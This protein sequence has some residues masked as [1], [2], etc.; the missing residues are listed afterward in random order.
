M[1]PW[2]YAD[3]SSADTCALC[4]TPFS[5]QRTVRN[6]DADPGPIRQ[7]PG[8]TRRLA[9][10]AVT[11]RIAPDVYASRDVTVRSPD[12]LDPPGRPPVRRP[13]ARRTWS[14]LPRAALSR[15][16]TVAPS[17]PEPWRRSPRCRLRLLAIRYR[18][19]RAIDRSL[20]QEM[21]VGTGKVAAAIVAGNR[22]GEQVAA[23]GTGDLFDHSHSEPLG[24]VGPGSPIGGAKR[25]E[26]PAPQ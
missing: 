7:A 26:V 12:A 14:P 23:G 18:S 22:T 6:R 21:G 4:S 13:G 25:W 8:G 11:T 3:K 2:R 19:K 20:R 1:Q 10:P 24:M 15:P 16:G 5:D 9:P 17:P